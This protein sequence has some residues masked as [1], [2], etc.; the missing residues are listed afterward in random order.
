LRRLAAL[1]AENDAAAKQLEEFA[2]EK[3]AIEAARD[4]AG[5]D[6]RCA[7]AE[8]RGDTQVRWL[9][10]PYD[11]TP[12]VNF[13][14]R[15]LQL[16]LKAAGRAEERIFSG[17]AGSVEWQPAGSGAAAPIASGSDEIQSLALP[18]GVN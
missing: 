2:A 16:A 14:A 18:P 3:T 6:I 9:R 13:P 11:E 5:Q 15:E 7:I 4:A 8:V 10:R 12:L 1:R 17:D